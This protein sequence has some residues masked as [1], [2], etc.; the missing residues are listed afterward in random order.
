MLDAIIKYLPSP[1]H[2]EATGI[3]HITQKPVIRKP[4]KKEKLCALAFKV[5]NDKEK[6]LVTFFRVYS[7]RLKNR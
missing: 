3:D 4:N 7:G 1:E 6:G 5:V 2:I